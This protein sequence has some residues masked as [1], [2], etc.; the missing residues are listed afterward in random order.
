M[1]KAIGHWHIGENAGKV[2]SVIVITHHWVDGNRRL[3]KRVAQ[4]LIALNI[5]AIDHVTG[6]NNQ[7][8]FIDPL[9]QTE[10]RLIKPMTIGFIDPVW[11]EA[12]MQICNLRN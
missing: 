7:I 6:G 1:D 3:R 10:D 2:V 12:E 9:G 4:P 11:F 5:T 8:G